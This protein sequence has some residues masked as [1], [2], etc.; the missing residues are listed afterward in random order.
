MICFISSRIAN[1]TLMTQ[2]LQ[3]QNQNF[4]MHPSGSMFWEQQ[5]ALLISDVHLGK[6]SHFRK[7]GAAVP[8]NAIGENF[9]LLDEVIYFYKPK[10][11]YFLGD[12]FHSYLNSEWGYFGNWVSKEKKQIILINGNHDIIS[13]LRYESLGVQI[14]DELVI[15][16]FLLT[17]HPEKRKGLFNFCGHIHPAVKLRGPGKQSIRLPCFIKSKG[18]MILPSFGTFTG[19]HTVKLKQQDEAYAI[20]EGTVIKI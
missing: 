2:N 3:I 11:I 13:P 16:K 10:N 7:F 9:R 8:R 6:V 1:F 14:V 5:S 12:L 20:A 15:D 18:Q 17:H 4:S 19:S